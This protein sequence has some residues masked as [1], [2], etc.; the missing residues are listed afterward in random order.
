[1]K[2]TYKEEPNS[3]LDHIL[4]EILKCFQYEFIG[5]GYDFK[6][7]ERDLQFEIKKRVEIPKTNRMFKKI[8]NV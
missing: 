1:M 3:Q 5:S 8:K 4:E 7:K 2:I 6:K